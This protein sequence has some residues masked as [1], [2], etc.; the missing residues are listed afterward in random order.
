YYQELEEKNQALEAERNELEQRQKVKS[1]VKSMFL[2]EEQEAALK[3]LRKNLKFKAKPVPNFYYEAP[4]AKPELKKSSPMFFLV[5]TNMLCNFLAFFDPSKSPNLTFLGEEASAMQSVKTF[6]RQP[7]TGTEH[8][9]GTVQNKNTIAVHDSPRFRSGKETS[10]FLHG[11]SQKNT[12]TSN[13]NFKKRRSFSKYG[14][15]PSSK[16]DPSYKNRLRSPRFSDNPQ[17]NTRTSSPNFKKQVTFTAR[18]SDDPIPRGYLC[19]KGLGTTKFHSI[20]F[21]RNL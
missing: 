13:P 11:D 12:R 1:M 10:I 15:G 3:Q 9:T 6:R 14:D 18:F 4:P 19:Y 20:L 17:K 7:P 8:S 2:P 16:T 21:S 5:T